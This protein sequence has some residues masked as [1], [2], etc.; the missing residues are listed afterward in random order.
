MIERITYSLD[1]SFSELYVQNPPELV[2]TDM[3]GYCE[4]ATCEF[5]SQMNEGWRELVVKSSFSSGTVTAVFNYKIEGE[6]LGQ[7]DASQFFFKLWGDQWTKPW[8]VS[9][10]LYIFHKIQ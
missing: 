5:Y 1:G 10:Q 3:S 6:I 9:Q 7:K 2:I 8:A 4:G